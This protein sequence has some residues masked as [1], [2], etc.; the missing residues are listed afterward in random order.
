MY[1]PSKYNIWD[2]D[3][4][5]N[6]LIKYNITD[7]VITEEVTNLITYIS[8]TKSIFILDMDKNEYSL[9]EIFLRSI[10]N[11]HIDRLNAETNK[12]TKYYPVFWS[13]DASYD[14]KHIHTHIDHCD[15]EKLV[16]NVEDNAPVLTTITYFTET[17]TI[18]TILTDVTREMCNDNNFIHKLNEKIVLVMPRILRH[19]SF[20]GGVNI[21]GE[22]YLDNNNIKLDRK[23]IV[24][25]LWETPPLMAPKFCSETFYAYI[26]NNVNCKSI[27][28]I[29][30]PLNQIRR[31]NNVELLLFK[32]VNSVIRRIVIENDQLINYEF[33][34]SL[35]IKKIRNSLFGLKSYIDQ[36]RI[37][38][39]VIE[40]D[41]KQC[42]KWKQIS[43][44]N[45]LIKSGLSNWQIDFDENNYHRIEKGFYSDLKKKMQGNILTSFAFNREL[46]FDMKSDHCNEEENYI[47][48]IAKNHIERMRNE[49]DKM[50]Y[51][52][53]EI[54]VSFYINT[55]E[56]NKLSISND[57]AI[58]TI[59][60]SLENNND[61]SLIT[62]INN[63]MYKYKQIE[64]SNIGV[65]YN[66]NSHISFAGNYYT[67]Y[68]KG[69]LIIR[70]WLTPP[71]NMSQY[72]LYRKEMKDPSSVIDKLKSVLK[73]RE[74]NSATSIII[75]PIVYK[76]QIIQQL[77]YNDIMN[78]DLIPV[79]SH[80]NINIISPIN[81][82][83]TDKS[84]ISTE[85]KANPINCV[86]RSLIFSEPN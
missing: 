8:E 85:V 26:F 81:I 60:T 58:Q 52:I 24:L 25:T 44:I 43:N 37:V 2:I 68:G 23:T 12:K 31:Y 35:I 36:N 78:K 40:F 29:L 75:D 32:L 57:N 28:I 64:N 11:F 72:S 70:L 15:Y 59:V 33:F 53:G 71:T 6:N 66:N 10:A 4:N 79:K 3:L 73:I 84:V 65:V 27:D 30:K 83:V 86:L 67:K 47:Y 41:I 45:P 46:L 14:I 61:Y 20:T 34:N 22:A 56:N 76:R 69:T 80:S 5:A 16:Y 7:E 82:T 63:D 48:H 13:K 18:P 77:L 9:I 51:D 42:V 54:Y 50:G 39:D 21:H 55:T 74:K 62:S 19:F 1:S 17:D 38:A 49:N